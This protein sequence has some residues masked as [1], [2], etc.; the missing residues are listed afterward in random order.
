[1]GLT[2]SHSQFH[3][4]GAYLIENSDLSGFSHPEQM[5]LAILVRGHRRKFPL[6][7]FESLPIINREN[8]KRLCIL[9]RLA[10][11]LHRGRTTETRP[12]IGLTVKENSLEL[13]FPGDWLKRHPLTRM[14]LQQEKIRL[15]EAGFM[16]G[17]ND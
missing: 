1:M 8:T 12:N 14:E 13:R 10:I 16:L 4:H 2:I 3:K 6:D 11:L 9:L 15:E 7:A 5:L 17:Y